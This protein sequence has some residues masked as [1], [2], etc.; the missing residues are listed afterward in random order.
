MADTF[1]FDLV[2]PERR[3]ASGDATEVHI[4][5][6][7]GDLTA[8]A[9]HT[10]LITTLRP[11]ILR[12]VGPSGTDEY[13]VTGGF[14]EINGEMASILAEESLHVSDLDQDVL[15]RFVEKAAERVRSAKEQG[16]NDLIDDATKLMADMVAI[17]DHI[18]LS[19][20][21]PSL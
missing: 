18:G 1:Q 8:M 12:I 16:D 15:D 10:P 19:A 9:G 14:A 11:G 4:P 2:S 3:L 7:E 17:G 6:A 21:Q 5:G 13:A 20:K